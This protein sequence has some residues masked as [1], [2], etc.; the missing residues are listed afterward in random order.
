MGNRSTSGIVLITGH[1]GG[2]SRATLT[3]P[4]GPASD[5]LELGIA[6]GQPDAVSYYGAQL[7][8]VRRM[9]GRLHE[10]IP[11]IEQAVEDNPGLPAFRPRWRWRRAM[12]LVTTRSLSSSMS[13]SPTTARY[14]RL[15][16]ADGP[17]ELVGRGGGLR[18][19]ACNG[20]LYQRLLPVARSVR[21][22][23]HNGV[24][25]R[26]SLPRA[27]SH[28]RT[29]TTKL[30]GGSLRRWRATRVWRRGIRGL[31]KSAWAA[32]SPTV[33]NPVM[34]NRRGLYWTP[35]Y[36]SR[37]RAATATSSSAPEPCSNR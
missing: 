31:H 15:A 23:T 6:A 25:E 33:T 21:N 1:C 34:H 35:P 12:T 17:R 36:P 18:A 30:T 7:T 14:R 26:R 8:G 5:A 29:V 22:H 3:R 37:S 2:W 20:D 24:W 19:P 11:L 27:A 28:A 16:V 10:L 9:R 4:N 32:S 13:R